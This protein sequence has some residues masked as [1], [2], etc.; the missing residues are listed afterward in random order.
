[1]SSAA[2]SASSASHNS[3]ARVDPVLRNALRYTVSAREYELL[4]RYLISQAP[5]VKKRSVPPARY[6]AIV[7][8]KG[9]YNA[10]AIRAS[11]RV[12]LG[13]YTSCKL[14]E[15]IT[16]RLLSKSGSKRPKTSVWKS[17]NLRLSASFSFILL[18]YR[19][20]HR[21]FTRL[22][23]SLLT[24]SAQPFRRRNPRVAKAL[25]S[26]LAPAVGAGLSGLFLGLCPAEQ[27]RITI[28]IYAF[29]RALEF[30]YN[31]LEERGWF[32]NRPW[33]F[34][35][36]LLMPVACGQLLHAFVFDRDCFPESFGRY[37]MKYS[38]EYI[39]QRPPNYPAN[40]PWPGTY[41]IVDSL[42]EISRLNWP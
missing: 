13:T 6:E 30:G 10:A 39:Q 1:M 33:W 31:A 26:T 14:W 19:L 37:I 34:G 40:K 28:T 9:D 15:F 16:E 8:R 7:K 4:H 11:I 17:P 36:W 32:K 25:T 3:A 18:F 35:S 23:E 20:L 27:L 42:A 29:T 2:S 21:F 12:F 22:R 5:A 24:E 38:P 41:D